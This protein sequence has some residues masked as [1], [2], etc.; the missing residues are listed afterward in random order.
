E[1]VLEINGSTL[2]AVPAIHYHAV[3]A[4]AVNMSCRNENTRPDAIAV[5]LGPHM[6]NTIAA[7]MRELG[8]GKG[9][10]IM[11]PCMLGV[12]VKN[13]LI[14]PDFRDAAFYIQEHYGK[15][16]YEINSNL[17]LNLLR[18]SENYL[19]SLSSTD[20]IIEAIRSAIILDI[21]VFG[22][23]LDEFSIGIDG[24]TMIQEPASSSFDL[25]KYIG[26]NA[27]NAGTLRDNYVDYRREFVMCARLKKIL[28]E[29]KNI[30]LTCGLAH[31]KSIR[32][33]MA[34]DSV[35]PADFLI[36][37]KGPEMKKVIIHPSI[38]LR[39]M[40]A[41]PVI[42]TL[43]EE[44]RNKQNAEGPKTLN[45]PDYYLVYREILERTYKTYFSEADADRTGI[46][47]D[48]QCV[49]EFEALLEN[50]RLMLQRNVP[51]SAALFETSTAIMPPTYTSVLASVMMD[52]G[53][54]WAS[55]KQF[56][57]LPVICPAKQATADFCQMVETKPDRWNPDKSFAERSGPFSVM[58][59]GN[60]DAPDQL[61]KFWTWI[62]EPKEPASSSYFTS[63]VWP[64]CEALLY[65]T[66][67]DAAKVA[68]ARSNEPS[69]A[70]FEGTLYQGIDVKATM[71]SITQGE[72]QI[73]IRKP[74]SSKKVFIPDG[75]SPDPT[76]FIFTSQD[77]G[78][79]SHW[80]VLIGGN[81]IGEHIRNRKRFE[82][83]KKSK[84]ST[85][86]ASISFCHHLE[87]PEDLSPHVDGMRMLEG[88]TLYGNPCIN[89]RQGAQ[90]VEDN[91][92]NCCPVL[93]GGNSINDLVREYAMTHGM[94][95]SLQTWQN[96]LIQ[97]AI[98]YAKERVVIIAPGKL[99]IPASLFSE[100]K[101]RNI[102]LSIVPLNYF[103]P[104]RI[105]EMRKRL[106]VR[107]NDPGGLTFPDEVEQ[108]LG[109]SPKKYFE[110]LPV[111]MQDQLR[112]H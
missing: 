64:P 30:L 69:P 3:F 57:N 32:S 104:A 24:S 65:G 100:A 92:Y 61:S 88:I 91:D 86:I 52:I 21:P 83:L 71:R 94:E 50:V 42:T 19:V 110:M 76:V 62:D 31:W 51:H 70:A 4:Q 58:F 35:K 36:S 34:D 39:F 63:W 7:W 75:K 37:G 90:W 55:P 49:P 26:N 103:S 9:K 111:Y 53:R 15:P 87:I 40:D 56:P 67:H 107:S 81:K 95:I 106:F 48:T 54:E 59:T 80:S 89:A 23:D 66:A 16:L 73:Y 93:S 11:L 5:E 72:N 28:G 45:L 96:A 41:Y 44:N 22:V 112:K 47:R 29:Y 85:F 99:K 6:V 74:S 97:F 108:K 38:S 27:V 46:M 98:P 79:D 105:M 68:I 14:H 33:M 102:D 25:E 10:D 17:K 12:L 20:S 43:Y 77:E 78:K 101:R 84:G 109:Q 1:T 8:I 2:R 13:R 82:A 18:F 60:N